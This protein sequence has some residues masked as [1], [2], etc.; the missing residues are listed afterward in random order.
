MYVYKVDP[1]DT[2]NFFV[3]AVHKIKDF[4][5]IVGNVNTFEVEVFKFVQLNPVR[6]DV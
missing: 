3:T 4:T 2:P 5:N 6:F 1:T